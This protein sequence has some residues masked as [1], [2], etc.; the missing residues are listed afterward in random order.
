MIGIY[1]FE[2]LINGRC[3][4]G[5]SVDIERRYRDHLSRAQNESSSEYESSFHKAI[6][7]YGINNFSFVI[8]EECN[9]TL[10]NEREIY[11][12]SYYDSYANGY[13][14][15]TGGNNQEQS[16]Q[17]DNNFIALIQQVLLQ[18]D[19][20]YEKI[21]QQYNISL[22]RI[23]E[24]NTGK[25]GFNKTLSY[26]LRQKK[27]EWKCIY[28]EKTISKGQTACVDCANKQKRKIQERP[29]RE[30]LK[31]EIRNNSFTQIGKQ[32]G[33]SDNTIRKWCIAYNL[34]KTKKE[35]NSISEIDWINI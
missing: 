12:I 26:P 34:P 29:S 30:D 25:I 6:R 17:F 16:V 11:W 8:L 27:K 19:D 3:Y 14:E 35:I 32:Y 13:N 18:S 9:K 28:C 15:T 23:S 24:I 21:H 33:V 22:G 7:K 5:Q 20:T 10:L 4:I 2:N 1:K 31:K